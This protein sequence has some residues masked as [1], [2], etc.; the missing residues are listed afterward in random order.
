MLKN[1]LPYPPPPPQNKYVTT[2]EMM[3]GFCFVM[4]IIGLKGPNTGGD[5]G[6]D[7]YEDEIRLCI[8]TTVL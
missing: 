2:S 8:V 5:G 3:D 6:S 7:E 1:I 4:S